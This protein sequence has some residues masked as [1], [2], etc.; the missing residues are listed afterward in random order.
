MCCAALLMAKRGHGSATS[1]FLINDALAV[2]L[3][4]GLRGGIGSFDRLR[5]Q[6][7]LING[8]PVAEEGSY[9]MQSSSPKPPHAHH[10]DAHGGGVISARGRADESEYLF[11]DRCTVPSSRELWRWESASEKMLT[12][13]NPRPRP[14]G[15]RSA[16]VQ[17]EWHWPQRRT[18]KALEGGHAV[19][20]GTTTDN[21]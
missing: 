7:R 13:L 5:G 8:M 20:F 3:A 9:A 2:H 11:L 4:P 10:S 15:F 17:R 14:E 21:V 1:H 19:S 16:V 12:R 6:N 18:G